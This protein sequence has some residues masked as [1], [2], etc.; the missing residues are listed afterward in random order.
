ME[1]PLIPSTASNKHSITALLESS[2]SCTFISH[3]LISKLS[4]NPLH[5]SSPTHYPLYIHLI[6][7]RPP[8]LPFTISQ[9]FPPTPHHLSTL[10]SP[11]KPHHLSTLPSPP[12]PHHLST[13]PPYTSPSLKPPQHLTVFQA[14]PTPHHLSSPP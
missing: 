4:F 3:A 1:V 9:P 14:S 6:I 7:S 8:L 5:T 10:P 11:P 12:K 2:Q 13:P